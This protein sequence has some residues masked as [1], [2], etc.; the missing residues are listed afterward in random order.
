MLALHQ[1]GL[2]ETVAMMGT[3]M[4]P[5]QVAELARLAP[6]ALLALDADAPARRR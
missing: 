6:R 1:A 5:E 4:T 2:R 3:A